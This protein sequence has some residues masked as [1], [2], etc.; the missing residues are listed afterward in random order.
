M[1]TRTIKYEMLKKGEQK[2]E[3][4]KETEKDIMTCLD[5]STVTIEY[6]SQEELPDHSINF[7]ALTSDEEISE[8]SPETV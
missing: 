7:V 6:D 2:I 8:K 5:A 3:V 4:T 1:D